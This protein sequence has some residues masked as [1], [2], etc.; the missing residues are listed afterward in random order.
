MILVKSPILLPGLWKNS[1]APGP[2]LHSRASPSPILPF[3]L[4]FSKKS[5]NTVS[6]CPSLSPALWFRMDPDWTKP[7][8]RITDWKRKH[9]QNGFFLCLRWTCF[10]I[11]WWAEPSQTRDITFYLLSASSPAE[12]TLPESLFL[13]RNRTL[14]L[15]PVPSPYS[16]YLR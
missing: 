2:S 14:T 15:K 13:P 3:L 5:M 7:E 16:R 6:L 12:S 9:R 11:A 1:I 10:V 8:D 4:D